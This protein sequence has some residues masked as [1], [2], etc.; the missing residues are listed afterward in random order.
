MFRVV[1]YTETGYLGHSE[2]KCFTGSVE[3][4]HKIPSAVM[5]THN[6]GTCSAKDVESDSGFR[7]RELGKIVRFTGH[8]LDPA[9]DLVAWMKTLSIVLKPFVRWSVMGLLSKSLG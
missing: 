3:I 8:P 6:E 2:A 7:V 9:K 5:V 4:I 1:S